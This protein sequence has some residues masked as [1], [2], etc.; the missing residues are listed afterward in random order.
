MRR[1]PGPAWVRSCP[2]SSCTGCMM[3]ASRHRSPSGIPCKARTSSGHACG[4]V[5]CLTRSH[6]HRKRRRQVVEIS[7]PPT[8]RWRPV[9]PA[10]GAWPPGRA[11]RPA[12]PRTAGSRGSR[13][14]AP[15][16]GSSRAQR[17]TAKRSPD[18]SPP[19]CT[20]RRVGVTKSV[21]APTT[22]TNSSPRCPCEGC[23]EAATAKHDVAVSLLYPLIP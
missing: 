8:S 18:A 2:G 15:W 20:N 19:L 16:S 21:A 9:S 13:S 4:K 7:P 12:A 22:R 5:V 10:A 23:Q 11:G 1:R 3:A 14:A 6:A 17:H